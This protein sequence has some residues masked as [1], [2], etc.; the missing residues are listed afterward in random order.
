MNVSELRNYLDQLD[1]QPSRKL[2][3]NF[4]V[5]E[6]TSKWIAGRLGAGPDTTVVEVGPGFGAL[7]AHLVGKVGKLILVEKDGRLAGFLRDRYRSDRVEV[8]H[9]DATQFDVR[10][11]FPGG[12]VRFLGNLPYSTGSEIMRV[13]L[14]APTPVEHAVV[15][16]QKEVADRLCAVPRTKSY[17]MISV[18]MQSRWKIDTIKTVGP[19]LFHPRPEVDSSIIQLTPRGEDEL[20][21][22][23]PETFVRVVKQ[24]FSQRRKQLHNNLPVEREEWAGI[25]RDLGLSD[26]VRAEE[27][28]VE[29]WVKLSNRIEPHPCHDLPPSS[30]EPLDY[31]DENDAVLGQMTRREIHEKGAMHRA[32]HVF[33]FN[34]SGELYLQ[35]R[36]RFKDTHA[37]KCDSSASGHVDPGE[38]YREC[39]E[40]ELKEEL[41]VEAKGDLE[42]IVRLE[43]GSDTDQEFVEVFRAEVK[44]KIRVHTSEIHSGRFFPVE[45]I[46]DWIEKRP[47]DFATGF[48][49]CYRAWKAQG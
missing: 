34:R 3:Q 43:A 10:T 12:P 40:R 25:C 35:L 31:V 45:L 24:G 8:R 2:G 47:E 22:Y 14:D 36:S 21:R 18:V 42:R 4:L 7:T 39:G 15:M 11:L 13:F 37:G 23:S 41:G 19:Q 6:N 49:T 33:V 27:L 30:G 16:L 17:G 32:V 1:L 5:D 20:P 38:G 28:S 26:S 44:G 46:D 48:K 29:D 9:E